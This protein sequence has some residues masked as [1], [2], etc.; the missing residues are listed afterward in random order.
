[1]III[2]DDFLYFYYYFIQTAMIYNTFKL[3]IEPRA[4][5]YE[6]LKYDIAAYILA[7]ISIREREEYNISRI[8]IN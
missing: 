2:D 8:I 4:W 1:M 7:Y 6:M 3:K 5:Y